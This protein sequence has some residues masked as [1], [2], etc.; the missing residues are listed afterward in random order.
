MAGKR[1]NQILIFQVGKLSFGMDVDFVSGIVKDQ[2]ITPMPCAADHVLGVTCYQGN[3]VPVYNLHESFHIPVAKPE[4]GKQDQAVL[5]AKCKGSLIALPIDRVKEIAN[6]T[7]QDLQGVPDIL[8]AGGN[9]YLHDVASVKGQLISLVNPE[10][11]IP[12]DQKAALDQMIE[13]TKETMN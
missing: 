4:D 7:P 10:K 6:L 13:K 2:K 1:I 9:K 12:E 11:L 5:M 8:S 3:T